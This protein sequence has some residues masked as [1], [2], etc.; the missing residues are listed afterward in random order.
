[1]VLVT[2]GSSTIAA[3]Q[4]NGAAATIRPLVSR[5]EGQD[6]GIW[7]AQISGNGK[8]AFVWTRDDL[9][10]GLLS[11]DRYRLFAVDIA[12]N[13]VRLVSG[14]GRLQPEAVSSD[15]RFVV[16]SY[17]LS[18]MEATAVVVDTVTGYVHALDLAEPLTFLRE[19]TISADGSTIAFAATTGLGAT[20]TS[21]RMFIADVATG[22]V[23][24]PLAG[25]DGDLYDLHLNSDATIL[26]F[27]SQAGNLDMPAGSRGSNAVIYDRVRGT[28]EYAYTTTGG[29]VPDGQ[30]AVYGI[31][32]DGSKVLVRSGASNVVG[33][34]TSEPTDSLQ[35][36][37]YD[38][39]TG[40]MASIVIPELGLGPAYV[41]DQSA[42]LGVLAVTSETDSLALRHEVAA[43]R[44]TSLYGTG[45]EPDGPLW[46][47]A[48][49]PI[50]LDD[51]GDVAVILSQATNLGP[52]RDEFTDAFIV[53]A[54]TPDPTA[55]VY[56]PPEIPLPPELFTLD[57][58]SPTPIDPPGNDIG[59]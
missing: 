48:L 34:Q 23:T 17:E 8:T 37:M 25:A 31:S 39:S 1:M 50:S 9:L 15:G 29:G 27:A 24:E 33:A 58:I 36:F 5:P 11:T 47:G 3:S 6:S 52:D 45:V 28:L 12:T 26:A 32:A 16:G 2:A 57:T 56:V 42:D 18:N 44:S 10:P 13:Q 41:A 59:Y 38:R 30:S 19:A 35:P 40:A 22:E 54:G 55:Q 14:D 43:G 49:D 20:L 21:N 7:W 53:G 51:S 4:G 46:T